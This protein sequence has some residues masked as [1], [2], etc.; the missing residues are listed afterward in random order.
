MNSLYK[1]NGD[2]AF[3]LKTVSANIFDTGC[4]LAVTATDFDMDND[5]DIFIANDFG[6]FIQPNKL[7]QNQYPNSSYRSTVSLLP[8]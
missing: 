8:G 7:Y 2:G 3:V 4:A 1:N 6:S 5:P